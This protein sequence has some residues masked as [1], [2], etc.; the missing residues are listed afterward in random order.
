MTL[1]AHGTE[2]FDLWAPKA[3][4]VTLL[5]GGQRYPMDPASG[6]GRDG[7]WTAPEAPASGEVDYGY[8]LD[9][10][11][12]PLPDPRSRRQPGG[13]HD[14]SRTFDPSVHHWKDAQWRGRQLAGAVIYELHL[15]TF[16]S[17][18]TLEAASEKLGYLSELGI[19]F[20]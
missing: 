15:G 12:T 19:D 1:P 13:V 2:R 11:T 17:E 14:L 5:A 9:A 4:H 16:T 6:D 18:G 7:W 3:Q 10:D 20:V 8:L